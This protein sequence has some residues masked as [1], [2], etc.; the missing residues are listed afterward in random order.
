MAKIILEG[1][2]FKSYIGVH[3]FEQAHGNRFEVLLEVDSNAITSK[4]DSIN[5]T[6]D[7]SKLYRICADVMQERHHIIETAAGQIVAHVRNLIGAEGSI[8][9][10]ICK[11]N[12]PLGGDVK[13]V[14]IEIKNAGNENIN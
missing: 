8:L 4:N 5:A 7:Y 11:I 14:C 12:P 13:K 6:I 3:D 10:R 1:M 9:I 2:L